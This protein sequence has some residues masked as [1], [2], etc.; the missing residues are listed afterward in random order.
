M[1]D[2]ALLHE[3]QD[4]PEAEGQHEDVAEFALAR[5]A[6]SALAVLGVVKPDD[7]VG[8]RCRHKVVSLLLP[9]AERG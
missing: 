7:L 5:L 3:G 1:I 2:V 9:R 4:P 8:R 6:D